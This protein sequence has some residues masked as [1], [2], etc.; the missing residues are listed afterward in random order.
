MSDRKKAGPGHIE[1]H[2]MEETG[3]TILVHCL[4]PLGH[5][6]DFRGASGRAATSAPLRGADRAE[7]R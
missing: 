3:R 5:D 4:C 7:Q 2:V 1:V 6:H